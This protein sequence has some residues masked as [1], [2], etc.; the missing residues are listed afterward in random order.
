MKQY[1]RLTERGRF[2][3]Y[4]GRIVY[5]KSIPKEEIPALVDAHMQGRVDKLHRWYVTCSD[6]SLN[7]LDNAI[8]VRAQ[9]LKNA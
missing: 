8:Y 9:E 2:I 3:S 1:K 6:R 5:E 4:V 7:M